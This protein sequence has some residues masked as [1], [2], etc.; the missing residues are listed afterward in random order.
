MDKSLHILHHRVNVFTVNAVILIYYDMVSLRELKC[1]V[2][3][4]FMALEYI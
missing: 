4:L 2:K 1:K 3:Y